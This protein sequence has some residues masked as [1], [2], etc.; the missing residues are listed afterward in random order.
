MP[1]TKPK[2]QRKGGGFSVDQARL[3]QALRL[4]AEANVAFA[5][6]VSLVNSQLW[7]NLERAAEADAGVKP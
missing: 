6:R 4:D 1:T 7:R 5:K 2:R 3:E